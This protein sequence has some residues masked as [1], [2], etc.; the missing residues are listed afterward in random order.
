MQKLTEELKIN[1]IKI[2][3]VNSSFCPQFFKTEDI[4]LFSDT[5]YTYYSYL[6]ILS[7]ILLLTAMLGAIILA[8]STTEQIILQKNQ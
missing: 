3:D 1:E 8:L 7:G 6:F 5:F 4:W 2:D